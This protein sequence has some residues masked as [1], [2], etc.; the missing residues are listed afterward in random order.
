M[1]VCPKCNLEYEDTENYCIECGTRLVRK[2]K[3]IKPTD[4]ST[5]MLDLARRGVYPAERIQDVPESLRAK[6]FACLQRGPERLYRI[7]DSL[8]R[9]VYF[10]RLN[11]MEAWPMKG[12]FDVVFCR[13]VM[14]YFDRDTRDKLIGRYWELLSPGG[15]LFIGHS[16]GLTGTDHAFNYVQPT[17]Y[18]K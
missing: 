2:G 6:Y 10:A 1:R 15:V 14:I 3:Q 9:M 8:R 11:L 7:N 4:L 17:V 13:N 12:P 5:R 18:V 16:E